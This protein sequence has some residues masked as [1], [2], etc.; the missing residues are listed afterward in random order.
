MEMLRAN[1]NKLCEQTY[2]TKYK[3][4]PTFCELLKIHLIATRCVFGQLASVPVPNYATTATRR[5]KVTIKY[6][7][8]LG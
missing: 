5:T 6:I 2:R 3:L 1:R 4:K 7:F 8:D